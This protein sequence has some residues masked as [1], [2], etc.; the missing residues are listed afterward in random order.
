MKKNILYFSALLLLASCSSDKENNAPKG[1]AVAFGAGTETL[2]RAVCAPDVVYWDDASMN[3]TR[4][5]IGTS[6][7]IL[8]ETDDHI[9]ISPMPF[10][11]G[12]TGLNTNYQS[13]GSGAI[14]SFAAASGATALTTESGDNFAAYYPY[15][16]S[17]NV[18]G[19][20]K[21]GFSAPTNQVLDFISG[22]GANRF[23]MVD[24]KAREGSVVKFRFVNQL[25]MIRFTFTIDPVALAGS[26]GANITE[27][28]LSTPT[29]PITGNCSYDFVAGAPDTSTATG[30]SVTLTGQSLYFFNDGAAVT[31]NLDF[32][33]LPVSAANISQLSL[34]VSITVSTTT[35]VK[36]ASFTIPASTKLAQI[37][38]NDL[39]NLTYPAVLVDSDFN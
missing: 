12:S 36:T 37:A 14:V 28:T 20:N 5:S 2:G 10:N 38:P 7:E 29:V 24:Q 11:T 33:I 1:D 35:G 21:I 18:T 25:A 27:V 31:P 13:Q 6:N 15:D 30:T 23:F 32:A 17:L 22:Y 34:N 16:S 26:Q 9:G 19:E 3:G 8:W 39:V 4:T